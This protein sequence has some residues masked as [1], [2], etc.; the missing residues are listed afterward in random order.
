MNWKKGLVILIMIVGLGVLYHRYFR[1]TDSVSDAPRVKDETVT[2]KPVPVIA[3]PAF[4]GELVQ[5]VTASGITEAVQEA[6]IKSLLRGRVK[7]VFVQEG[8]LVSAGEVLVQLDDREYRIALKEAK[9]NLL[10]AQV[11]YGLR[12][13][14]R[15]HSHTDSH[16]GNP[17]INNGIKA[18]EE[19][20][21]AAREAYRSG[22]LSEEAFRRI[23]RNYQV[24]RIFSGK[25][26]EDLIAQESGLTAAEAQVARAWYNVENCRITA[27]FPGVASRIQ[28]HPGEVVSAGQTLLTLINLNQL[29][30]KLRILESELGAV[31]IGET[32]Y[33]TFAAYPD[34]LFPGKI[35]GIDPKV[36]PETRTG[37]VIALIENRGGKLK[38]GMFATVRVV[39]NRYPNRL[40]VPREAVVER[41]QRQLVF[42]VRNGKAFWCYVETGLEN[43]DYIEIVSSAFNLK[44]GEL[45]IVEGHFALAHN[46]PVEVKP[47]GGGN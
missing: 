37:T 18:L 44:A 15:S 14:E 43:D 24:A 23:E 35:I 27:P 20:Y 47:G 2:V 25:Y 28:V 17:H 6:E 21:E 7:A 46:A 8:K 42:I 33:A 34:T 41:D 30:L 36:D 3:Q 1:D 13:Q 38:S 45:V 10:K 31:K 16:R 39:V 11:E 5:Y 19:E 32:I 12:K 26:Q 4:I 9:S 40:L 29:E 22:H